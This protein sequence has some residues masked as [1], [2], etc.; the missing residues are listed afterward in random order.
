MGDAPCRRRVNDANI[1]ALPRPSARMSWRSR[2]SLLRRPRAVRHRFHIE[3]LKHEIADDLQG[4][5]AI[6]PIIERGF[7]LEDARRMVD[8]LAHVYFM[9]LTTARLRLLDTYIAYY[10]AMFLFYFRHW[11][12]GGGCAASTPSVT[13]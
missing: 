10:A 7:S 4:S 1:D 9:L 12:A 5:P 6:S 13:A 3:Q 11:H 2:L 8:K